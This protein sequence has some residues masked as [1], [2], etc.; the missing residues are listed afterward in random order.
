MSLTD[1]DYNAFASSVVSRFAD[2]L[3]RFRKSDEAA[4][5]ETASSVGRSG[6]PPHN[7]PPPAGRPASRD[8]P[9]ASRRDTPHNRRRVYCNFLLVDSL[10]VERCS[11]AD[12][13]RTRSP[14]TP[15]IAAT[16]RYRTR[17]APVTGSAA[18]GW[19]LRSAITVMGREYG[20]ERARAT[21]I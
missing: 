3:A 2:R 15:T 1:S 5:P 18:A 7:V 20:A 21:T 4:G 11:R 9:K 17:S 16:T 6:G 14:V 10:V 8:S 12:A 19:A 13:R